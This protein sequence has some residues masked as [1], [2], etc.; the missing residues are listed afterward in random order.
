M[1]KETY[2]RCSWDF[3]VQVRTE[4][5]QAILL[6]TIWW[7]KS[8]ALKSRMTFYE[9]SPHPAAWIQKSVNKRSEFGFKRESLVE[10][11]SD[12]PFKVLLQKTAEYFPD[13][14]QWT[15]QERNDGNWY[16][17]AILWS[18]SID[19]WI[20]APRLQSKSETG[21]QVTEIIEFANCLSASAFQY[22]EQYSEHEKFL[23]LLRKCKIECPNQGWSSDITYTA[24]AGHQ[25]FEIRIVD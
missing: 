7:G 22:L 17:D 9:L 8:D 19:C 24:V 16:E 21:A 12:S 6:R 2:R 10:A 3:S 14:F 4:R 23:Y 1:G 13:T 20:E 11:A 18:S 5:E 15:G 25:A